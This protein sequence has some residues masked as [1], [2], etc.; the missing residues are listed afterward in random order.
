MKALI[1]T[2]TNTATKT[3]RLMKLARAASKKGYH[4]IWSE[5]LSAYERG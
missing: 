5:H 2:N 3:S 1:Q 4:A